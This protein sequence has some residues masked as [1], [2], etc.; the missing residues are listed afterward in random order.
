[1]RTSSFL[2]AMA[3]IRINIFSQEGSSYLSTLT[4]LL[5]VLLTGKGDLSFRWY[6]ANKRCRANDK[7]YLAEDGG[8]PPV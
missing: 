6:F 7:Y 3:E 2:L 1:M 8:S 4:Y 5:K